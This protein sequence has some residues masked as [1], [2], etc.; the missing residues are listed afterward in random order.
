MA[1]HAV[2]DPRE[3]N[4]IIL[5]YPKTG[6]D[7]AGTISI[8]LS[9]L[10]ISA[11]LTDKPDFAI[12][13]IDQRIEKKWEAKLKTELMSSKILCVGISTMTGTQIKFALK[14]A[15]IVR[16]LKPHV[17]IIW[18]G[19]HPTLSPIETIRDPLVD[20]VVVGEAENTFP[21]LV[22]ALLE[23]RTLDDISGIVYKNDEMDIIR[24]KERNYADLDQLPDIPY[25]LV[26]T[27]K[28]F[29]DI[30]GENALPMIFS[31]GCPHRCTFCYRSNFPPPKWRPLSLEKIRKEIKALI[32]LGARTIIPL[33][34]NFFVNKERVIRIC[35][36]L[37]EEKIR[38]NF[39]VN[40][41]ID[42]ADKMG[43]N[44]LILLKR[45]GFVSWDFGIESGS[46]KTLDF[47]KKDIN[48]DQVHRVNLKLK[49]VGILPTY[50]FM[51]GFLNETYEDL[52][53]TL[54][55]MFKIITD[56]PEAHLS[57]IKIFT[58]FPNTR[59]IE[60]LPDSYWRQPTSLREWAKYDYNTPH[61][62]WHSK[63][64]TRLLE[65]ISFYSYFI[66]NKRIKMILGKNILLRFFLD[67][68][69]WIARLRL[70]KGIYWFPVDFLS[71]KV[72]YK[73]KKLL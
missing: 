68:Y 55:L 49:N 16:R 63:K 73:A 40:C 19:V 2:K 25:H 11:K 14:A 51:G 27:T 23:K 10:L 50:S 12:S 58:P 69:S 43:E 44:E 36:M 33:D 22:Q 4:N 41:R 45:S 71:M 26:D 7:T 37:E 62:T 24:T 21:D 18:G 3:V 70:K 61:I 39:H 48:I 56:Y 29:Y 15:D 59:M 5:I 65:K 67:I 54:A 32:R 6:L 28:Y 52:K 57:P 66:D 42:Y 30:I 17:P 34:D 31:R 8:P 1:I 35:E 9:L 38:L 46:Q 47:M 53:K 13:I 60:T 64:L 72:F 20:I